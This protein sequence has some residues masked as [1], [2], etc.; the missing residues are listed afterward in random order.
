MRRFV[1]ASVVLDDTR[2]SA[3]V[4]VMEIYTVKKTF[5]TTYENWGRLWSLHKLH[6]FL[7]YSE[8]YHS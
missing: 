3:N 1:R 8:L 4:N 7:F 5:V 2:A 6:S